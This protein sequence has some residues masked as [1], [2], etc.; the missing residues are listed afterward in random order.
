MEDN[1]DK[2]LEGAMKFKI[3]LTKEDLNISFE[4]SNEN[5]LVAFIAVQKVYQELWDD[6]MGAGSPNTRMDKSEMKKLQVSLAF[7]R[8]HIALLGSF[9][10]TKYKDAMFT[11]DKP[12][13]DIIDPTMSVVPKNLRGR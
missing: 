3:E 12:K 11:K 7:L 13:I 10:R 5:N 6:Q 2:L 1:S 8:E 9:V 4:Q